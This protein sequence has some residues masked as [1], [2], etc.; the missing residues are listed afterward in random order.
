MERLAHE[1]DRRLTGECIQAIKEY[2]GRHS[3]WPPKGD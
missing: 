1:H 3:L 2:L